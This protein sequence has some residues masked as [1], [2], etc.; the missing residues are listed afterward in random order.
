MK[1]KSKSRI[2]ITS[3]SHDGGVRLFDSDIVH[4]LLYL[5]ISLSMK[6]GLQNWVF[7]GVKEVFLINFDFKN[8]CKNEFND[9]NE[10]SFSLSRNGVSQEAKIIFRAKIE[11]LI[12]FSNQQKIVIKNLTNLRLSSMKFPGS[13]R[14]STRFK[15]EI[16]FKVNI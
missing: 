5:K 2:S 6:S 11:P 12:I 4:D 15:N 8:W 3:Y 16:I 1:L 14:V 7:S 13:I 10:K 9:K